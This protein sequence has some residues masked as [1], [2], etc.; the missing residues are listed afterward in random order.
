[1]IIYIDYKQQTVSFQRLIRIAEN[2]STHGGLEYRI[3]M[4][5]EKLAF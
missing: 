5:K 1:M 4:E 3:V 2:V